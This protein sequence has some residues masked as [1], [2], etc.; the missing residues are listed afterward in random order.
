MRHRTTSTR[1]PARYGRHVLVA[2]AVCPHP[3]AL[4]PEVAAG[5]APELDVLRAACD[6]AV[7]SLVATEPQLMVVVGAGDVTRAH[8]SGSVGSF[9]P[10]GVDVTVVLGRDPIDELGEPELP[11]SLSVG[12]WLLGRVRST[13]T[14][15][16]Y[17]VAADSSPEGCRALGAAVAA[18]A[19]RVA[20]L[21]MGDGSARR[22]RQAPGDE[23]ERAAPFDA[24][25]VRALADGDVAALLALDPH[26]ARDLMV[27]GRAAWQVLAGA[28]GDD[29]P[30]TA[31]LYD[32][33]PYGVEYVVALWEHHG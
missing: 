27:A 30:D 9:R 31:V 33:A 5:A 26:E 16:G 3:P 14:V 25:V 29:L 20:L 8:P 23:D 2:A 22:S 4:V 11:L 12:A 18:S 32:A 7:E 13:G 15:S 21:V 10:Y 19:D 1:V 6:R 28:A 24:E 17:E